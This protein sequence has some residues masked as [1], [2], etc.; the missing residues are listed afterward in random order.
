MYMNDERIGSQV[1]TQ[2]VE[3]GYENTY[4]LTGG[5]EQFLEEYTDLVE[6][7]DV[8][9]PQKVID[10]EKK[11]KKEEMRKTKSTMSKITGKS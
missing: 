8:P 2:M 3:K 9:T 10:E 11:K 7:D 1:A 5:I 4:M 6:G